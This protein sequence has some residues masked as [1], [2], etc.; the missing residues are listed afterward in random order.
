MGDLFL[1][2]LPSSL[3][4]SAGT[5]SSIAFERAWAVAA[6][7]LGHVFELTDEGG[8]SKI[9]ERTSQSTRTQ[10]IT[11]LPAGGRHLTVTDS[12][13]FYVATATSVLEVDPNAAF[14]ATGGNNV[15]LSSCDIDGG[16]VGAKSRSGADLNLTSCNVNAGIG[17]TVNAGTLSVLGG[18]FANAGLGI[19]VINGVADVDAVTF[20]GTANPAI[21]VTATAAG[22]ALSVDDATFTFGRTGAAIGGTASA[23]VAVRTSTFTNNDAAIDF[24]YAF[25][26]WTATLA[27]NNFFSTDATDVGIS[28]AMASGIAGLVDTRRSANTFAVYELGRDVIV[29]ML[30]GPQAWVTTY[31]RKA[32]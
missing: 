23:T 32:A 16:T 4:D 25:T 18:T 20:S 26:T 3:I 31:G 14:T 22:T 30:E 11:R 29:R 10:L 19:N 15:A 2:S 28:T 6:D 9:H 21:S 27:G 24:N 13:K 8:E 12:G 7:G 5:A 1:A 17:A